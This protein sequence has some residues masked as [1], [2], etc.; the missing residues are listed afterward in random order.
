MRQTE[1]NGKGE[2]KCKLFL[3]VLAGREIDREKDRDR[4]IE[5]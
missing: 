1:K 2:R 3:T 4:F 5:K